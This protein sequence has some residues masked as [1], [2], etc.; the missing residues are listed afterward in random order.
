MNPFLN[1]FRVLK[2]PIWE[3]MK[4]VFPHQSC[5]RSA[6]PCGSPI[7]NP[8][9]LVLPLCRRSSV[10][11]WKGSWRSLPAPLVKPARL[12]A[13]R[14]N[15]SLPRR[16]SPPAPRC[17]WPRTNQ[18]PPSVSGVGLWE[19]ANCRGIYLRVGTQGGPKG[20]TCRGF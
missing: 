3:E 18:R 4:S 15:P 14:R 9:P 8:P 11:R 1:P 17:R 7:L 13:P 19:G 12:R 6:L 20:A 10:R 5:L 2:S 16:P